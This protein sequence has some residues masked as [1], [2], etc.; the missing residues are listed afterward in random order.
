MYNF[1]ISA[2][3]QIKGKVIGTALGSVTYVAFSPDDSQLAACV[4]RT[5]FILDTM[6]N[7]W[8][9]SKYIQVFV[10]YSMI[11]SKYS[12]FCLARYAKR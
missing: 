4:D 8:Y 5:V 1:L 6:V 3:Q 12:N 7:L 2:G 11:L 10:G 9:I